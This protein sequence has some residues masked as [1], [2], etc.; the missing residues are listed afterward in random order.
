MLVILNQNDI[1][2]HI[3][4]D[5]YDMIAEP[6]FEEWQDANRLN[7]RVNIRQRISGKFN[8]I[9]S[10][11]TGLTTENFLNSLREKTSSDGSLDLT[12]YVVNTNKMSNLQCFYK[13]DVS[14]HTDEV[15]IFTVALEEC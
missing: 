13:V 12:V 8:V 1:T 15:T 6:I 14:K 3:E 7:H 5:S 9:C 11:K 2:Q 4:N 10:E